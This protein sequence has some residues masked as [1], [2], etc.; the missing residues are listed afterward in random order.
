MPTYLDRYRAG[1]HEQVW[2][3]L[4]ALGPAVRDEPIYT[5]ARAVAHETMRRVRHNIETLIPRLREISYQFGDDSAPVS[6]EDRWH[7]VPV[8]AP[9][10]P[11]VA[12]IIA[13]LESQV[14][15]L[16][17]SLRAF[18][19]VVGTVNLVGKATV[20][21][22]RWERDLERERG[23]DPLY[24]DGA[25]ALD[26][27]VTWEDVYGGS[28]EEEDRGLDDS[29]GEDICDGHAYALLPHDCFLVQIAPDW[30]LKYGMSGCGGYEIAVPNPSA[31]ARLL[32]EWHRTTFV[33]YL[34]ICFRW[35]G[36]PGWERIKPR[37][38]SDLAFLT[39]GLLPI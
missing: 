1:A 31:D 26:D 35:G 3:E 34:R 7:L 24:V 13:R 17:L 33:N 29:D 4:V 11:Q 22:G 14:G 37:P 32:T 36:F 6:E 38:D 25:E 28:T 16:P 15:P 8:F 10:A 19:E 21:W 9:P 5:D 12:T 18:Y 30:D 39:E 20:T 2:A 23:L 27:V